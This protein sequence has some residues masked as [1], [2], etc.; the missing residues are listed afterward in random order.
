MNPES[1]E[2]KHR[3]KY[4]CS[5]RTSPTRDGFP[6]PPQTVVALVPE[7]ERRG[8]VAAKPISRAGGPNRG[9]A[10]G[11]VGRYLEKAL[12]VQRQFSSGGTEA[13]IWFGG[14]GSGWCRFSVSSSGG[15]RA[16]GRFP[17]LMVAQ[18]GPSRAPRISPRWPRPRPRSSALRVVEEESK[19]CL[20]VA[21][22][23]GGGCTR[24]DAWP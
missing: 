1:F 15:E 14:A 11:H 12:V 2:H 8:A 17:S 7:G 23:G 21:W 9:R 6:E 4:T 20:G 22:Y 3:T 5:L 10:P 19:P 13:V 16:G 18:R 24:Y